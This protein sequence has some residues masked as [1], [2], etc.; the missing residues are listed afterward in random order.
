MTESVRSFGYDIPE[1]GGRVFIDPTATVIGNVVLGDD[2]SVWPYATIRGDVNSISIDEKT[3]IQDGAVLHVTHDGPYTPGGFKLDIG[4]GVTIGHRA[5]LHGCQ[6]GDYCLIGINAV[7][8]DG[9]VIESQVMVGAGSLVPPG[10]RLVSGYLYLGSP[11][12]QIRRLTQDEIDNFEYSA[13]H[14]L[15]LKNK[16]LLP[17][18]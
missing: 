9:A 11:V 8:L 7:V 18:G 16:Y 6:L 17:G 13:N 2:V 1:I 4:K 10:K 15:R 3:N 12:K 14:Y 5:V